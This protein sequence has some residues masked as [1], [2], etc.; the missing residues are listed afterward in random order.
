M[1]KMKKRRKKNI[2][3]RGSKTHGWGSKKKHRGAGSR[4]GRGMAGSGKRADQKKTLILKLYGKKYFGKYGFKRPKKI[5]KEDKII[6]IEDLK[7]FDKTEIDLSK[8][9]YTKLLSRGKVFGK[10]KVTVEKASKKAINKIKELGGEII[11]KK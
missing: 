4:G 2:K 3:L 9:G 5:V 11:I 1:F 7:K 10:L 6:N 8:E